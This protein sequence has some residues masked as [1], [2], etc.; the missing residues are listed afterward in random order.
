MYTNAKVDG[1]SIKLI[2]DSGSTGSIITKQLMDQ[3]NCRVDHAVSTRII[4]ADGV[5]KTL[6]G[7]ID[8]FPI[9]VNGIIVPIKV[10][11][12]KATQYQALVGNNWLSKTNATLDWNTQ[13][14]Q[15]SQNEKSKEKEK[16]KEENIPEET[17]TAEEITSGWEREYLREPIKKP[18]YIPLKCKDCEKKLSSIGAWVA[19]DKDYWTQTHYYCKSCH[20]KQYGYPKRQGK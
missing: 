2:L 1:H 5:T 18:P 16:E 13:E 9:E 20:R 10:L 12:M 15:L 4:T 14:L 8:D 17:T 11:V 19:P 7:E 3:L 6:I